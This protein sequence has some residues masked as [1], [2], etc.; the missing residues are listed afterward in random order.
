MLVNNFL[1][2]ASQKYP[3]KNAVWHMNKWVTYSEIDLLSNAIGNY[4][5][6]IGVKRGDRVALLYEN[7]INCIIAYFGIIKVG[8]VAVALNT[9]DKTDDLIY[10]LNN[11][12]ARAIITNE[13]Y[14]RFLKS[15]LNQTPYLHEVLIDQDNISEYSETGHCNII[16][17]RDIYK[18]G[19]KNHPSVR[20]IDIDLEAIVYT[21]GSTGKP[22]GVVHSHLNVVSNMRSIVAYLELTEH[23]RIMA[24]LPFYYIYGKSLFLSHFLCGGS[25]VIDNRFTYP[26]TVL[27]NIK[28]TNATGFAGVPSTFMILLNRSNLKEQSFPSLRYVTQAGGAMA[29][30]VQ[31]EIVKAFEPAKVY[32]MY[33]ATEAAPRLS[34]LEP[35]VLP[36]KW[37]SI[38]KPVSNVDLFVGD[39]K[40]NELPAGQIGEIVARG[41]NIMQG[42]WKDPEGTSEVLKNGLY[43]TGDLGI[44][45]NEG[46]LYVVGRVKDIIKVKG[47]RVSAKEI[48]EIILELNWVHEVAVIGVED[49][50]LGEAIKAIIVPREKSQ[51]DE[52]QI[53]N[54]LTKK[55]S[56]YK[57]PKYY[58]F[59]EELPKNESGKIVKKELK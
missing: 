17:L 15:A 50:I 27:E 19:N 1:E 4:L 38:G 42:Y 44:T 34:Y 51:A 2:N 54:L 28:E 57:L 23:D 48:E 29:P 49:P 25:V 30:S 3:D 55:L 11:S 5:K 36:R 24:I 26:N 41:S 14:S 8:A 20:C 53:K 39:D 46:Y 37:G 52:S 9:A 58:E 16:T 21:S 56:D 13:K 43:Y 59:C 32:I 22:K 40:G 45:D 31:K 12:D 18:N 47:F 6:E 7:S 33:G 35:D 10:L